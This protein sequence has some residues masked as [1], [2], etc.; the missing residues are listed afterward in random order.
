MKHFES[1]INQEDAD[2]NYIPLSVLREWEHVL[3]LLWVVAL[4]VLGDGAKN[5]GFNAI[6]IGGDIEI[7]AYMYNNSY[8]EAKIE[9]EDCELLSFRF[10][11]CDLQLIEVFRAFLRNESGI[12]FKS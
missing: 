8:V 7:T 9:K 12:K 3:N 10:N 2:N 6:Y 5:N 11:G 4:D 1:Q